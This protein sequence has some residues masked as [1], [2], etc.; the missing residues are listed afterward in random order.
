MS[1]PI[2]VGVCSTG[3]NYISE[4]S[5]TLKK[6]MRIKDICRHYP[7]DHYMLTPSAIHN[8]GVKINGSTIGVYTPPV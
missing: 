3:M 8:L 5:I 7:S 1:F 6:L 2:P 4:K